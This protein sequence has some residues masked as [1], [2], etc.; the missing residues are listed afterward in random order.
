MRTLE[1]HRAAVLALVSPLPATRV[2]VAAALGLVLAQDVTA[3][4]DLPGFD[5]SAMDGYAVRASELAG[6][7]SENPVV[8]PVSGA[9]AAGDTTR[10]VLAA[11]HTMRIMTGA[12]LP[13]GCDAVVPVELTEGG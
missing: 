11:G 12:S 8:L 6:A 3:L 13:E 4:V 10:H 1:E 9:I 2:P 7:S 5:N